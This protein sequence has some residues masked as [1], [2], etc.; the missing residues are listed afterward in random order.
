MKL[1]NIR[2]GDF[3]ALLEKA[4]G[5]VY[6]DTGD[7]VYFNLNS[8]LSQ[9]YCIKKLLNGSKDN[10]VSPEIKVENEDDRLMFEKFLVNHYRKFANQTR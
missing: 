7:G 1:N 10:I 4:Q 9:L 3:I 6:L 2:V 8:K 5:N